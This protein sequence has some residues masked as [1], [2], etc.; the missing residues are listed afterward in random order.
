MG[1]LGSGGAG[2]LLSS[3]TGLSH[4]PLLSCKGCSTAVGNFL[5]LSV[6]RS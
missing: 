5:G 3:A 4:S 6:P 2:K 1:R